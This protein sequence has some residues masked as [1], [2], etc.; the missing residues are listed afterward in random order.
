MKTLTK[1]YTILTALFLSTIS[2]SAFCL[3]LRQ[4]PLE[5][6]VKSSELVIVGTIT[7]VI[8]NSQ[9]F[10]YDLAVVS[11]T[12][13]LKGVPPKEI[14]VTFNGTIPE[15]QPDCC[16]IGKRYL[17]FVSKNPSGDYYPVNGPYGTY[18][19]DE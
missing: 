14:K 13:V 18:K 5:E 7:K 2:N 6:K 16:E 12:I 1:A 15:A 11:P 8:K 3:N 19:L 10:G 9:D 17:F 4:F